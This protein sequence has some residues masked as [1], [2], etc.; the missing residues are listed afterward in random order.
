ML[1]HR[2]AATSGEPCGIRHFSQAVATSV[3]EKLS[4]EKAV[5]S[6]LHVASDNK[7]AL[8][9][10][11]KNVIHDACQ[12]RSAALSVVRQVGQLDGFC[13]LIELEIA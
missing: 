3:V 12:D 4:T 2:A 5:T 10:Q 9:E 1:R 8:A 6:M 13:P 11:D 7:V